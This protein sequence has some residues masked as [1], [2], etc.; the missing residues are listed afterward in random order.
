[1]INNDDSKILYSLI[2]QRN[3][4]GVIRY[5]T[6]DYMDMGSDPY[7]KVCATSY[8]PNVYEISAGVFHSEF[9]IQTENGKIIIQ[10]TK[11]GKKLPY[12]K[13]GKIKSMK[14]A[15]LK[16]CSYFGITH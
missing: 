2:H 5:L 14:E 8:N 1:M 11:R 13:K 10:L 4:C 15:A 6:V 16:I 12:F 9:N 3:S 7:I